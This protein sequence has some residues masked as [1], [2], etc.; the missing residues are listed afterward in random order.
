VCEVTFVLSIEL[1]AL[2]KVYLYKKNYNKTFS[3]YHYCF[4]YILQSNWKY[5]SNFTQ[6][7]KQA[8]NQSQFLIGNRFHIT[9]CIIS[10][11][12]CKQC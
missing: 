10:P 6:Q 7:V 1:L 4:I 5:S 9:L 3:V 12:I 2:D 11:Y 8:G